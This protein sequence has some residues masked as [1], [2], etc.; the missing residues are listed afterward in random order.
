LRPS[1]NLQIEDTIQSE[2]IPELGFRHHSSI[3]NAS[4]LPHTDTL[5]FVEKAFLK[6]MDTL[7]VWGGEVMTVA[8]F[9]PIS[10]RIFLE[11]RA[12][13]TVDSERFSERMPSRDTPS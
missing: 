4:G 2:S 12:F 13:S 1:F 7:R 9:N 11:K 6:I 5:I 8:D 3:R 10:S